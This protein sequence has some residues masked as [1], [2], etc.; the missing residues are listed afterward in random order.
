MSKELTREEWQA[1]DMW[2]KF[3]AWCKGSAL[4]LALAI[5][6]VVLFAYVFNGYKSHKAEVAKIETA[7][8]AD[9]SDGAS[10]TNADSKPKIATRKVASRPTNTPVTTEFVPEAKAARPVVTDGFTSEFEQKLAEFERKIP[11]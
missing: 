4:V 5:G 11:K 8:V 7:P 1:G 10:A 2:T 3:V 9:I 6:V